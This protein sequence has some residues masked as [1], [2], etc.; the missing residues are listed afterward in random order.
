MAPIVAA[1]RVLAFPRRHTMAH[2]VPYMADNGPLCA[3]R[4]SRP[5]STG[6]PNGAAGCGWRSGRDGLGLGQ[7]WAPRAGMGSAS[8]RD[9]L[10]L[11]Q[12]WARPCWGAG[13]LLGHRPAALEPAGAR[14]P[15][16][17]PGV[18]R[19][20]GRRPRTWTSAVR[21]GHRP[22]AG[23]L[24]GRAQPGQPVERLYLL[25]VV[26]DSLAGCLSRCIRRCVAGSNAGFLLGRQRPRRAAGRRSRPVRTP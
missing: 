24:L 1:E 7:G 10:G 11:G 3:V 12:G 17:C 8:G 20:T 18:R 26:A 5:R 13:L 25:S 19:V 6:D 21:S 9:G 15:A 2:C 16:G 22:A 4:F 14:A 23:P